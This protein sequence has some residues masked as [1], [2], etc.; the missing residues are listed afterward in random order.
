MAVYKEMEQFTGIRLRVTVTVVL[1]VQTTKML[2]TKSNLA[3]GHRGERAGP[4][5]VPV[6]W[7]S[8]ANS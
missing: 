4:T 3:A 2:T 1:T 8:R 6:E 5:R 7:P